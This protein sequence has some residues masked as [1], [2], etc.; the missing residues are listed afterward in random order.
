MT[1]DPSGPRRAPSGDY[2]LLY[3]KQKRKRVF[4]FFFC[5]LDIV[6]IALCLLLSVFRSGEERGVFVVAFLEL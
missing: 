2:G 1:P 5:V 4:Y 6:V 3:A